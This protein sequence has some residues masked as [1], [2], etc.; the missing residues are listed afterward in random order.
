MQCSVARAASAGQLSSRRIGVAT[1][2]EI[3]FEDTFVDETFTFS[4]ER[5]LVQWSKLLHKRS[6]CSC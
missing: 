5:A 1:K 2:K 3:H 4:L 6:M